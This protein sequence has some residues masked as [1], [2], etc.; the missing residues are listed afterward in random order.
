MKWRKVKRLKR[1]FR[2]RTETSSEGFLQV[3][4]ERTVPRMPSRFL[5]MKG[6]VLREVT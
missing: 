3:M 2:R 4:E 6:S 1:H 5:A